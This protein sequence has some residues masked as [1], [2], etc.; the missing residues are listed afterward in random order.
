MRRLEGMLVL[1][2]ATGSLTVSAAANDIPG[3][4]APSAQTSVFPTP[5]DPWRSWGD[6]QNDARLRGVRPRVESRV[7]WV[8]G[9][10]VWNG[11]AWQWWPGYWAQN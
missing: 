8:P 5:R 10:W 11:M 2:L 9:Q 1:L 4:P 6:A 3:R 7:V